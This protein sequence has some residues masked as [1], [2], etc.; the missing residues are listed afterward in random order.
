M[1]PGVVA[2]AS[3]SRSASAAVGKLMARLG[4]G[5]APD[6]Y[7]LIPEPAQLQRVSVHRFSRSG[8]CD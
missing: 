7:T 4:A 5:Q 6:D 8:L 1:A 3:D 2:K